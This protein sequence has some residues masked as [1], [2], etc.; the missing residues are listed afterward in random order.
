METQ[1]QAKNHVKTTS[2]DYLVTHGPGKK[3]KETITLRPL[4]FSDIDEVAQIDFS[5]LGKMRKEYWENK[6]KRIIESGVP[7]LAA[8][9]DG[10]IIGFILGKAS[11]REYGI[12][13]NVG[14]ID[15]IGVMKEWQGKGISQLLFKEMYSI[16]KKIGLDT[17][18]VF[19]DRK[20]M[21][22]VKFFDKMGFVRGDMFSMELKI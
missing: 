8:E 3:T 20:Q 21:D 4:S 1:T 9:I 15:T 13:D 5:L 11:E 7:S 2:M 22:L 18:Y 14:Y 19:V 12:P 16:L 17:I 10:K 6:I